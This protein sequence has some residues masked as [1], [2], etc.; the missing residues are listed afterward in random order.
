L[1]DFYPSRV[2]LV[3]MALCCL[4]AALPIFWPQW[5][6]VLCCLVN[7]LVLSAAAADY[8]LTERILPAHFSFNVPG[9]IGVGRRGTLTINCASPSAH[10]LHAQLE[11]DAADS[12]DLEQRAWDTQIAPLKQTVFTTD[13]VAR[14]RE[15]ASVGPARFRH[16]GRFGLLVF[17]GLIRRLGEVRIIPD[18]EEV[19]KQSLQIHQIVKYFAGSKAA[20]VRE[21]EGEFDSLTEYIPGMDLRKMDWKASARHYRL[22]SRQYRLEQNHHVYIAL[23]T[24]RLMGT[25]TGGISKLDWAINSALRL[26]FTA[27]IAGDNV[28]M[29]AFGDD[30]VDFVKSRKGL[31]QFSRLLDSMGRLSASA[32]ETNFL[33]AFRMFSNMQRRRSLLVVFTDFVDRVSATLCLEALSFVKDRHLVLFVA[34]QDTELQAALLEKPDDMLAVHQQNEIFRLLEQ[35]RRVIREVQMMNVKTIDTDVSRVTTELLNRYL[36]L[37]S[38]QRL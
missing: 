5:G 10:A 2:L 11:L 9:E 33:R 14:R 22:F 3:L 29:F 36:E 6:T 34:C 35:R 18:V 26:S 20:R 19:K 38:L 12:L 37:K 32:D 7:L 24:G 17:R 30:V 15:I 27:L 13:F 23:D 28:G 4:T 25:A 21:N 16:R 31:P 1:T 8:I